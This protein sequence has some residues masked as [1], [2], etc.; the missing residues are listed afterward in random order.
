MQQLTCGLVFYDE[1]DQVSRLITQLRAQL[2]SCE[3][4][5][6]FVLNHPSLTVRNTVREQIE[7]HNL[8]MQIIENP[9]NNLG[10]ARQLILQNSKSD[11]IYF[12]DPD[13]DPDP[14]AIEKLLSEIKDFDNS[15]LLGVGG[16]VLH[17]SR[18]PALQKT[19]SL[20]N[21]M[22]KSLPFGYQI[23]NHKIRR[24][25]DHLPTCHLLLHR[26]RALAMGG[27]SDQYPYIGED[28][29]L[30][31]AATNQK[32]FYIFNPESKVTHWQ[33]LNFI[34]WLTKMFRYGEI[35]IKVQRMNAA[36]GLRWYRLFPIFAALIF[37]TV[38]GLFTFLFPLE[39]LLSV[40]SL[41]LV[42]ATWPALAGV[43][44]TM[45]AYAAGE[46]YG[47]VSLFFV[48]RNAKL[49]PEIKVDLK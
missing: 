41:L 27:F 14:Q 36:N 46:I 26:L 49:R 47:L 40:A 28:L 34:S 12:T 15:H 20:L 17:K 44:L 11:F 18:R 21:A 13:I 7:I 19:L 45:S 38:L 25:T 2:K 42:I 32:Y 30:S 29:N 8:D 1:A 4:G 33:N 5:W 16:L 37:V 10:H 6:V 23:Q 39:T 35:Q 9:L 24:R 48:N 43:I 3:S 31:H 22:M